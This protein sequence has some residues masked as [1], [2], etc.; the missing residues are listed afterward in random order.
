MGGREVKGKSCSRKA[1]TSRRVNWK[2]TNQK[3]NKRKWQ[4]DYEADLRRRKG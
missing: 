4:G 1:R 3:D 2:P